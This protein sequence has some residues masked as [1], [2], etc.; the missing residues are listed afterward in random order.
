MDKKN[1]SGWKLIVNIFKFLHL[2]FHSDDKKLKIVVSDN[3]IKDYSIFSDRQSLFGYSILVWLALLLGLIIFIL[4]ERQHY[5]MVYLVMLPDLCHLAKQ[6]NQS[7]R[8]LSV[9]YLS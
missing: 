2:P 1:I 8:I 3:I 7:Q 5:T 6:N 9:I 4:I